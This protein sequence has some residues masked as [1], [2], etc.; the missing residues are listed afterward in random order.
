MDHSK[1]M[2]IIAYY[3]SEYNIRAFEE[4]GFHTQNKGFEEIAATFEKKSSYLRRLRDEYDAVTNSYRRGQCNRPPRLRV[5]QTEVRFIFSDGKTEDI[6]L[7]YHLGQE[8]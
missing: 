1:I 2:D 3:L 6:V 4:L 7:D 5:V 8:G